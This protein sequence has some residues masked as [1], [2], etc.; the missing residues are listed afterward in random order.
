MLIGQ[1]PFRGDDE[2]ELFES[3]R[4]DT[5]RYPSWITKESK[6]LMEKLFVRDPGQRLGVVGNIRT[7]PFFKSINWPTLERREMDPPFKPKVKSNND[8]SN[9]DREFLSEKPRLS[10]SDKHFIDSM[11]PKAFAGFSFINPKM[12]QILENRK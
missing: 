5:P 7:H 8:C 1:S 4:T 10:H 2:D 3:I 6:D 9:F 12:E 11:D